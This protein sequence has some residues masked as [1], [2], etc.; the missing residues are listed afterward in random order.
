MQAFLAERDA[1]RQ[2]ARPGTSRQPTAGSGP[3]PGG[4]FAPFEVDPA[5]IDADL[6]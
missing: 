4:S 6:D 5:D 2:A 3:G 1:T